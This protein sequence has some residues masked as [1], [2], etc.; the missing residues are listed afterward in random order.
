[1]TQQ[2][3]RA[4]LA[5]L[6]PYATL[7]LLVVLMMLFSPG[8]AT[9]GN[10][11]NLAARGARLLILA[12]GMTLVIVLGMID[13]SVGSMMALAAV[14]AASAAR[15]CGD[16]AAGVAAGLAA[17]L[18]CGAMCGAANG[19]L[20][21]GLRIPS[22]I[23]TLGTL[24]IYRGI[25]QSTT[26]AV[27]VPA[28]ALQAFR[29]EVM[30]VP[31]VV[32]TALL[33]L[34]GGSLLLHRTRFGRH[35][36]AIG[37]NRAAALLSGVPVTRH[38]VLG[39]A[40]AGLL[41]GL[42]VL[43]YC[44]QGGSGDPNEYKGLELDVIAAVVIGGGSLSGGIGTLSGSVA[45]TFTILLLRNAIVLAGIKPLL[46]DALIGAVVILAVA[47]DELRRRR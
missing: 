5:A 32:L 13:L 44:A 11:A 15:A 8:F 22:F 27:A 10:L 47:F 39:Y 23:A 6:A 31:W 46:Q 24:G 21:M 25:A 35:T 30:G 3:A 36:Y 4:L 41:W 20:V 19:L 12:V 2:A 40:L 14:A 26:G 38:V 18:C 1:M 28:P 42:G 43:F 34:A 29:G 45:G 37:G 17:G 33:V 7:V 9:G 16:T